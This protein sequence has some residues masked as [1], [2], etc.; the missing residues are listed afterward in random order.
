M[1]YSFLIRPEAEADLAQAKLWYE[2][3]REGLGAD[4]LLCVDEALQRVCRN[5]QIYPLV[6]KDVRRAFVR[7]FPYGIF[8][9]VVK[10]RVVILGVVHGRRHPRHWQSWPDS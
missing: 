2:R 8:Y 5:P 3:R 1:S 6:H 4:F 9:R 10:Q 7:R